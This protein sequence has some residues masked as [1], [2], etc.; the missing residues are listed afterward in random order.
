MPLTEETMPRWMVALTAL[1]LLNVSFAQMVLPRELRQRILQAVVSVEAFDSATGMIV[2]AGTG[3]IISPDGF[4]LTNFHVIG[5]TDTG[6][7]LEWQQIYT[8]DPANP[9][10]EPVFRYWARFVAGDA[11]LDLAIL[12]IV[13]DADENR[14]PAGTRFPFLP[15]GDSNTLLPGDPITVIGF[16]GISGYTV[17]FTTGI[18]SGFL[19]EDLISG[20]K[21][22][23]KTDAK[24]AG[25]NSGGAAVDENGVLIG[26]PTLKLESNESGLLEQQD[27]LR[28]IALAFPLISAHVPN[29]ER[30]TNL[31]ASALPAPAVGGQGA[32]VLISEQAALD[33]SDEMLRSGEYAD[34]F[35]VQLIAG[36]TVTVSLE[37]LDFDPYLMVLD[38][39]GATLLEIDD[40]V[41][42]GTGVLE[43]F[44]PLSSGLYTVVA[45]SYA[46]ADTGR[47]TLT[48]TQIEPQVELD[49]RYL[50]YP[51]T[52]RGELVP[53]DL[54][55]DN[56]KYLDA[57]A[58]DLPANRH[59]E[60]RYRSTTFD[61]YL[62]VLDPF[63]AVILEVDDSLGEGVNVREV[64]RSTVAGTYLVLLTSAI[65]GETGGYDIHVSESRSQRQQP[66]IA[67]S[68]VSAGASGTVGPLA[69]GA[70]TR[71]S[72]LGMV[73]AVAYHTYRVDVPVGTQQLTLDLNAD[74][75]VD[76]FV[77][78]GSDIRHWGEDGDWDL[79]DIE[80][81]A[82]AILTIGNPT[83]GTYYVDVIYLG[84]DRAEYTLRAR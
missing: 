65:A 40:S 70:T 11:A 52:V 29:V 47:Y 16:P 20:G 71:G 38:P 60:V 9:D 48:V 6:V 69:V 62:L 57:I 7:A 31:E 61:P 21:R 50:S 30:F 1:V 41:G 4:V 56:G 28:P 68:G 27:L 12:Q 39:S 15:L 73:D 59:F 53:R 42:A 84:A 10:Q 43:T 64:F 24:L 26:V 83:P 54:Q 74:V 23:I 46:V 55:A 77:K 78:F 67:S 35:P 33:P 19:G 13:E 75:D 44:E 51:F 81:D 49:L 45:T 22:W 37:S 58:I 66:G 63:D 8:I 72:L 18:V 32:R 82:R 34:R 17:T 36:A 25:G 14:L 2:A 80:T 3:T 76:L 5:D 79:R